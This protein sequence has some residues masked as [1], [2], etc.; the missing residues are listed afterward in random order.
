MSK[1]NERAR[2]MNVRIMKRPPG[3]APVDVRDA[4]IGLS[5]PVLRGYS[6]P[7][8]RVGVGVLSGPRT[9]LATWLTG[10]FGRGPRTR[11]YIVDTAA[12][13]SLLEK[14]NPLAAAWWRTNAPHLLE[15]GRCLLFEE[16][17]CL[18]ENLSP[19]AELQN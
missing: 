10:F 12:A 13:V 1:A 9:W 14:A 18:V 17:C 7:I 4:W 15:P 2:V 16:D 8:R 3:E 11:G 5:V 6:R 19:E